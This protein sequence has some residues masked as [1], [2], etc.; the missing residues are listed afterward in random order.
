MKIERHISLTQF[1]LS[2]PNSMH[3]YSFLLWF[4]SFVL[5]FSR[6]VIFVFLFFFFFFF[7]AWP[8]GKLISVL[9]AQLSPLEKSFLFC[10]SGLLEKSFFI[11]MPGPG[12]CRPLIRA[13]K[14]IKRHYT[15]RT[16]FSFFF[17]VFFF[18]GAF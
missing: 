8:V 14:R 18:F 2:S 10:R 4:E 6:P 15:L 12:P 7:L 9:P 11:W 17:F 3:Y 1:R 16:D 13:H 5:V